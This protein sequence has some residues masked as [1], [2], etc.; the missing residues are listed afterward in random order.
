MNFTAIA[1]FLHQ[2]GSRPARTA[3][4]FLDP[5]G[6]LMVALLVVSAVVVTPA[7]TQGGDFTVHL[8]RHSPDAATLTW[9]SQAGRTYAVDTSLN[10]RDWQTLVAS[11][12]PG[13]ATGTSTSYNHTAAT[14]ARR[15][16]RVRMVM[17][18]PV[19]IAGYFL[20]KPISN[21]P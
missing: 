11:H 4:G 15:F 21:L 19:K 7:R 14:E 5:R 13:G 12:P 9:N 3:P 20:N 2:K 8:T 18:I 1:R 17:P 16:Y 10:L 6:H